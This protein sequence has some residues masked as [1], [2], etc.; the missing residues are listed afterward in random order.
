LTPNHQPMMTGQDWPA[1]SNGQVV[2]GVILDPY[3]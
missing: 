2:R 1:A 3:A